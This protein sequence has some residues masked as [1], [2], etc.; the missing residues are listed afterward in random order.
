MRITFPLL[1][2]CGILLS[3]FPSCTGGKKGKNI[4]PAN[5]RV[6]FYNVEN[7]FDTLDNPNKFDDDFT[8]MGRQEWKT[9]RYDKKLKDLSRVVSAME[10]PSILG[11]CEVENEAVLKD[12]ANKTDLAAHNYDIVHYESPDARGID[13]ALLYRKADFKVTQSEYIRVNFP[14]EIAEDYTSRDILHV[15]GKLGKTKMHFFVNHWPSRRGGLKESEP[16]R[17]HVAQS[18]RA[19]VDKIF[20]ADAE[21]K[22]ILMGDFN[23][24]PT[25]KSL[26]ET[27]GA[28]IHNDSINPASLYNCMAKLDQQNKGTY[29]Y[30]GNWNMLDNIVVSSTLA[31]PQS[32][33]RV[34]PPTLFQQ[35][36]MMYQDKKKGAVPNRTFGGPNYYGGFS[37]HLPVY[38][39]LMVK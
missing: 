14:V 19:A 7:L 13:V 37:D 36:W 1:L 34:G 26:L 20:A 15:E 8:P 21:A 27:L 25:N 38:V 11:L 10:F 4:L 3:V 23:D 17:V 24:E 39:D 32:S 22:I 5:Y 18:V 9:D 30:R 35:D 6:A 12:F 33:T 16:K 28:K 29:N 2:L 31:N